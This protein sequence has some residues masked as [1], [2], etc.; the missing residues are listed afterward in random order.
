MKVTLLLSPL[1]QGLSSLVDTIEDCWDEDPEARLSAAN[2]ALRL[3]GLLD[4]GHIQFE[5]AL[6]DLNSTAAHTFP[7]LPVASNIEGLKR[8]DTLESMA[9]TIGTTDSRPPPYD[10]R[11]GYTDGTNCISN[12]FDMSDT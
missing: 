10:I 6:P 12:N 3:K 1:H 4:S 5:H 8:C 11:W 9:D 2:V 7:S